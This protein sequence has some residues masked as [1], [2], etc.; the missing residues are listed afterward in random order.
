MSI[1]NCVKFNINYS[2]L[3]KIESSAL[4]TSDPTAARQPLRLGDPITPSVATVPDP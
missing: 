3:D 2:P 1:A 4:A